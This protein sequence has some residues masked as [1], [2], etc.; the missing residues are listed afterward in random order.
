MED[1]LD[2]LK[3]LLGIADEDATLD[4][5]L[6]LI[7]NASRSRL[8]LLLGGLEPPDTL[9]YIILDVASMRFNRLGSEGLSS[10]SVEGESLAFASNDF[11]GYMDDIQAYLDSLESE[12]T[13]K[14]RVR[15]L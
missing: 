3:L 1:K 10:H 2:D 6:L 7:L 11:A 14:G 15:F 12:D 8:K 5:K 4:D 9:D 13:T